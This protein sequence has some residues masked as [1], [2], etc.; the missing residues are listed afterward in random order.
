MVAAIL[1]SLGISG[2]AR[3]HFMR[4]WAIAVLRVEERGESVSGRWI[5]GEEE[6]TRHSRCWNCV[7]LCIGKE[8][9]T[10]NDGRG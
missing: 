2:A 3:E 4:D 10:S 7:R 8:Q 9:A 1:L 5:N 6:R